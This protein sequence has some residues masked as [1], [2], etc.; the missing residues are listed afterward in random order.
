MRPFIN[1]IT[2]KTILSAAFV[3][4]LATSAAAAPQRG[5]GG[6][7][8]GGGHFGG[9]GGHFSGGGHF[10]GGSHRAGG[11]G[12][13][14]GGPHGH[15][16]GSRGHFHGGHSHFIIGG[17]FYDP[18]WGPYYPYYYGYPYGSYAYSLTPSGSVKTEITPKQTEVF[19]DGYYAGVVADFDGTFQRLRTS[20]GGHTITL[21]LD[22]YRT[23]TESIYVRPNSTVKLKET[24]QKLAPG[25]ASTPVPVPTLPGGRSMTPAP[26]GGPAPQR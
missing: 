13:F 19:V 12:H 9:G 4:A 24:M 26:S 23:V 20:P 15:F 7:S 1:T 18:F 5:G 14:D 22:G 17:G 11:G 25:E 10:G 16:G 8:G 21:Y 2:K 3:L 6:H